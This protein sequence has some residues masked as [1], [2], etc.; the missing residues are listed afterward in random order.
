MVPLR[1]DRVGNASG[2]RRHQ[3]EPEGYGCRSSAGAESAAAGS[4]LVAGRRVH[5]D[6]LDHGSRGRFQL[7]R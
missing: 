5:P 1:V 6:E 3:S 4:A 7:I 2:R